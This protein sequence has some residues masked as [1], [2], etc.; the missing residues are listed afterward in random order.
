M[1]DSTAYAERTGSLPPQAYVISDDSVGIFLAERL[2]LHVNTIVVRAD[3][4]TAASTERVGLEIRQAD[5]TDPRS[6][7]L[8]GLSDAELVIVASESDARNILLAQILRTTFG[9]TDVVVRLTDP[10][11]ANAFEDIDVETVCMAS[12]LTDAI[13]TQLE[14]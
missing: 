6:L 7:A 13:V 14:L 3:D 12:T 8:A 2:A 1:A 10:R 4:E 5:V 11:N 9:V